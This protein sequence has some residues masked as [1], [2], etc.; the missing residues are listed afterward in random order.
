ML[1]SCCL[2]LLQ[3]KKE[4]KSKS[5]ENPFLVCVF[6]AVLPFCCKPRVD[7]YRLYMKVNIIRKGIRKIIALFEDDFIFGIEEAL[8]WLFCLIG[9]FQG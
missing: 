1:L 7:S 3:E 5:E 9:Q 6:F 4:K 2:L 8:V